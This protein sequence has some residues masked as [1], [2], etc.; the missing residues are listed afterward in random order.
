MRSA[1]PERRFDDL[2]NFVCDPA[3]LQA[4]WERV[5]GNKGARTPGVDGRTVGHIQQHIGVPVFLD[6]LRNRLRQQVW[7]PLPVRERSIPKPG[8]SARIHRLDVCGWFLGE[9]SL[10]G[11]AADRPLGDAQIAAISVSGRSSK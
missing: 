2:Y 8:G 6:V 11:L 3:T 9:R 10:V 5:A 4:A 7:S 1:E